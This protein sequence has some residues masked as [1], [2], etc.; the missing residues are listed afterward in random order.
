MFE[1][2]ALDGAGV[3]RTGAIAAASEAAVLSELEARKLSP[4]SVAEKK[5]QRTLRRGVPTGQLATSYLQLADLLR[6]GCRSS[7]AAAAGAQEE[8]GAAR[9]GVRDTRR[10]GL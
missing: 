4:V 8:R 10:G 7:A 2:I 3:K 1:Y 9:V 6:A 5:A